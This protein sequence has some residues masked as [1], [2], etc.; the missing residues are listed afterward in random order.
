MSTS[1][2]LLIG[3][4]LERLS[5]AEA[6]ALLDQLD[7]SIAQTAPRFRPEEIRNVRRR[8][9]DRSFNTTPATTT[10]QTSKDSLS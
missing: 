7:R 3:A 1:G 4:L 2:I 9:D 5:A 8:S 10:W 6:K